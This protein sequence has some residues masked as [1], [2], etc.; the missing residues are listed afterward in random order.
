MKK[1]QKLKFADTAGAEAG[2]FRPFSELLLCIIPETHK[3]LKRAT[4]VQCS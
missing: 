1:S 3:G 2:V 4:R